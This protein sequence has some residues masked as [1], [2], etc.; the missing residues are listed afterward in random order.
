MRYEVLR[1]VSHNKGRLRDSSSPAKDFRLVHDS[2]YALHARHH[3]LR[4]LAK[5]RDRVTDVFRRHDRLL[6]AG[7]LVAQY[8]DD[9]ADDA[10]HFFLVF[11]ELPVPDI[12]AASRL[13]DSDGE[14]SEDPVNLPT[15]R[16]HGAFGNT[17]DIN[18]GGA[19][20]TAAFAAFCAEGAHQDMPV[21]DAFTPLAIFDKSG[22]NEFTGKMLRP[23][24]DARPFTAWEGIPSPSDEGE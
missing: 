12:P 20:T 10:V 7:L 1:R 6:S 9:Q 5:I 17:V 8:W 4:I 2:V 14:F 16:N 22:R 3:R 19:R 24:L 15:Y 23:H 18:D 11:S 21:A 13:E